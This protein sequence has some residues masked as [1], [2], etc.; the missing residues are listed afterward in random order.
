MLDYEFDVR[1]FQFLFSY[2]KKHN[3]VQIKCKKY[4]QSYKQKIAIGTYAC[5]VGD[6]TTGVGKLYWEL[7]NSQIKSE[8]YV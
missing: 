7:G 6:S 1:S 3:T 4:S 8:I 5:T 2:H